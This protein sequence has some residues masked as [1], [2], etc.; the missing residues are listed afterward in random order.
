M[1]AEGERRQ[2]EALGCVVLELAPSVEAALKVIQHNEFDGALLDIDLAGESV[3]PVIEQLES[4]GKPYVIVTG[5]TSP[6]EL[7]PDVDPGLFFLKPFVREEAILALKQLGLA[8]HIG[9]TNPSD[10]R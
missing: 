10:N 1:I 6:R 7:L 2:L 3:I 8:G 5:F 9:K 4:M